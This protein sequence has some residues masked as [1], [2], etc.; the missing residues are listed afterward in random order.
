VLLFSQVFVS[1]GAGQD[2]SSSLY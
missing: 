1:N 2:I